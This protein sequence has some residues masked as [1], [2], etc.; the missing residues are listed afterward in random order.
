MIVQ[1]EDENTLELKERVCKGCILF[2]KIL[3]T[4]TYLVILVAGK[5]EAILHFILKNR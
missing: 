4:N 2:I 5:N 1:S 3:K